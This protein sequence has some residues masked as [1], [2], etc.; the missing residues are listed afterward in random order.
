MRQF[1]SAIFLI[2]YEIIKVSPKFSTSI[3]DYLKINKL[4]L[5]GHN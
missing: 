2:S 1:I 3:K 4:V 5:H